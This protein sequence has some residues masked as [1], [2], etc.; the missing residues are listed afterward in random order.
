[1]LRQLASHISRLRRTARLQKEGISQVARVVEVTP[2][3][4]PGAKA[5]APA[6]ADARRAERNMAQIWLCRVLVR[7]QRKR[8][9]KAVRFR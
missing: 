5:A 7:G 8:Q 1:M 6:T 2:R 4:A 9:G 3:G